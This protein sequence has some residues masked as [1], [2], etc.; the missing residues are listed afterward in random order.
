MDVNEN[1]LDYIKDGKI[2]AAVMPDSYTFGYLSMLALYT[3]HHKLMD[4]MWSENKS[5]NCWS[6]P[7][8]EVGSSIV[9][10]ENTDRYYTTEYY[11]SR[12]SKGFEEGALNIKNTSL[13]GYWKK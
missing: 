11:K 1:V 8:L 6:V 5:K 4:P 12:D 2:D 10:A 7:Y 3:E 13:P 9:T